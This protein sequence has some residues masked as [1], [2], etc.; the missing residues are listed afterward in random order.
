MGPPAEWGVAI[1]H[2]LSLPWL[3]ITLPA[4]FRSPVSPS[5]DLT[6]W[7]P[8]SG[9]LVDDP[10]RQYGAASWAWLPRSAVTIEPVLVTS[11]TTIGCPEISQSGTPVGNCLGE[12]ISDSS[13]ESA[14]PLR[15]DPTG[16][17]VDSG[18]PESLVCVDVAQT[19]YVAL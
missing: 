19:G 9:P 3:P 2:A 4:A 13:E 14:G 16:N 15:S 10:T 17:R 11:L 8:G 5:A 12:D 6:G 7:A 18:S 1:G